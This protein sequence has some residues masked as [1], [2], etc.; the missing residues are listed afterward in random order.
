M[1]VPSGDRA[2]HPTAFTFGWSLSNVIDFQFGYTGE[3][4]GN[5]TGGQRR[6]VAYTDQWTFG[7]RSI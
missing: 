5:A 2:N 1:T 6:Q 4:A 7:T 3:V